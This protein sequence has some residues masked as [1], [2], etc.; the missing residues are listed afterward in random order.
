M[1]QPKCVF[2]LICFVI[3]GSISLPLYAQWQQDKGLQ[4]HGYYKSFL[5]NIDPAKVR[6]MP[7]QRSAGAWTN[8]WRL[9]AEYQLNQVISLDA[10]YN[11][12]PK[13]IARSF[14]SFAP[15]P[16]TNPSHYRV[17][18]LKNTVYSRDLPYKNHFQIAQNLDR[19]YLS[20]ALDNADIYL[21]RQAISWGSARVI[22][23]TDIIAPYTFQELDTEERVGVDA[24]RIRIPTG[25][26]GE[27]DAGYVAG[28][29]FQFDKSALFLR[30]KTYLAET[31]VS[32]MLVEFQ[33]NLMA[34]ADFARSIGDAGSW[35]EAAYVWNNP[36]SAA[37]NSY[38]NYF[39]ASA[40]MDYNFTGGLY[41]FVEVHYNEA[42]VT[43]PRD[44]LFNYQQNS[45][46]SRGA[47]YLLAKKYF[48]PG[49]SYQ[50]TP[51]LTLNGQ[52]IYNVDDRSAFLAPVLEYN[53]TQNMYLNAGIY[54]STGQSIDTIIAPSPT[55]SQPIPIPR[56]EFGTYPDIYYAS[57]RWYF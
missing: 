26:M 15:T 14:G 31:D 30:G 38:K 45:A 11:L 41:G 4:F 36:F 32:L 8:R 7:D 50:L 40:G 24:L 17:A 33:K 20:I 57:F 34:G 29:H 16:G 42:G 2:L 49:F 23:P 22:N 47:V 39:R 13:V 5:V 46:Y 10:A 1:R 12:T 53:M 25:F 55:Q 27:I 56:S 43:N 21:G 37:Y 35:L 9:N 3:T 48:M 6:D 51:L 44:Y 18:D 28:R 54:F 52:V 19:L